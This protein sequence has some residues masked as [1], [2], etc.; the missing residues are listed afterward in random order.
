MTEILDI[1]RIGQ[2]GDGVAETAAG[3]IFVPFALP[4][5][6]WCRHESGPIERNGPASPHRATPP[7]SHFG[8]CGGCVAQHMDHSTYVAWKRALV[9]AAFEFHGVALPSYDLVETAPGT[10]RRATLTAVDTGRGI[11]LGF[12]AARSHDVVDLTM[13][14]V[15]K[16]EMVSALGGLRTLAGVVMAARPKSGRRGKNADLRIMV[17]HLSGALDIAVEDAGATL[18]ATARAHA[19]TLAARHGIQ[20]ISVDGDVV[21]MRD[22]PRI[23]TSGGA[24]VP[25]PAAFFQAVEAAETTMADLV[26]AGVGKAKRV[27][28]L[29]SGLGTFTLPL[30]RR[31][32]VEAVD[33]EARALAALT[34]A[35]KSAQGLK[36]VTTRQRDLFKEPLSLMELRDFDAA[37]LDPPRAG[38]KAQVEV[39]A[40]SPLRR[41][42]MVSC[43]PATLA[44]D[45]R[46]LVDGGYRLESLTAI[47]QFL[48]TAHVEV[49]AVFGRG[50]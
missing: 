22:A 24:I 4:G 7:C 32:R 5:E 47:D 45:A 50:K 13:C 26:C 43:N 36:P 21:V 25:A 31:S 1:V 10:R 12:H 17:S 39:I 34:Q 11:A 6:T 37:V 23:T 28:D 2:G 42:V 30:A 38:A 29:F 33:T 49:V 18:D 19:A 16:P 8:I 3:P 35:V 44:R 27:V 48:W 15:M 14:S 40:K 20:R 41:C 46:I 9:D